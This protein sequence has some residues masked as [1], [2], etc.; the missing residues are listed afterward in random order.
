MALLIIAW[1]VL[2]FIIGSLGKDK[3]IGF[4][5]AFLVS[6]FFSPIIGLLVVIASSP[7]Q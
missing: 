4:G 7:D 1:L 2:S 3:K 6:L 5:G